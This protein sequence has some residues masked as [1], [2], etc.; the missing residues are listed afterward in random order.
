MKF[1]VNGTPII[2][3]SGTWVDCKSCKGKGIR[4]KLICL[5]DWDRDMNCEK[6]QGKGYIYLT[7]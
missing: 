5:F 3:P 7:Y 4:F 6:C 2:Y 1:G